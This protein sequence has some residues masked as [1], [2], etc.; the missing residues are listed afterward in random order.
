M[1]GI[2]LL[3]QTNK[4]NILMGCSPNVAIK[5]TYK[6]LLAVQKLNKLVEYSRSTNPTNFIGLNNNCQT[7]C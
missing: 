1:I 7:R 3:K 4:K 2:Q 5:R 6:N